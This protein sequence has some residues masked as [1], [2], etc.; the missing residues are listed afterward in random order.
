MLTVVLVVLAVVFGIIG[1]LSKRNRSSP[2]YIFNLI[3][4]IILF[5]FICI[6]FT[7]AGGLG[8]NIL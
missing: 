8:L 4:Y 6:I 5:I 3:G 1:L 2:K 7:I